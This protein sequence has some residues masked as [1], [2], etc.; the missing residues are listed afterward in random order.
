MLRVEKRPPPTAM[1]TLLYLEDWPGPA[2]GSRSEVSNQEPQPRSHVA[3]AATRGR[4][5]EALCHYQLTEAGPDVAGDLGAITRTWQALL[6]DL[7]WHMHLPYQARFG[8]KPHAPSVPL[9][10]VDPCCISSLRREELQPA[11]P[12]CSLTDWAQQPSP[13]MLARSLFLTSPFPSASPSTT[14][15]PSSAPLSWHSYTPGP[16]VF[17]PTRPSVEFIAPELLSLSLLRH[18][19][20]FK[21]TALS[22]GRKFS[23][24]CLATCTSSKTF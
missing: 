17:W 9:A 2:G 22:S 20:L 10:L 1:R 3:A 15:I 4:A 13:G 5:L 6:L 16:S 11:F 21:K 18:G 19:E 23:F 14:H 8:R 7:S 24:L 12:Q